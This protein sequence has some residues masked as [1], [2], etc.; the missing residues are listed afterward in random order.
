M[1]WEFLEIFSIFFKYIPVEWVNKDLKIHTAMSTAITSSTHIV[2][3][4]VNYSFENLPATDTFSQ[5]Y[6]KLKHIIHLE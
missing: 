5:Y 3:A 6:V 2:A 4:Q 1:F